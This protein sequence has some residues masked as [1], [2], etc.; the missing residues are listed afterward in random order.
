[1]V[2]IDRIAEDDSSQSRKSNFPELIFRRIRFLDKTLSDE[3]LRNSIKTGDQLVND[4]NTYI[5]KVIDEDVPEEI[6]ERL[7]ELAGLNKKKLEENSKLCSLLKAVEIRINAHQRVEIF[8]DGI[9]PS[10]IRKSLNPIKKYATLLH[11]TIKSID[12]KTSHL[13][14]QKGCLQNDVEEAI[15]RV[16]HSTDAVLQDIKGQPSS[17]SKPSTK[18]RDQH[19][20]SCIAQDFE[21]YAK[22]KKNITYGRYIESLAEFISLALE[23]GNINLPGYRE[24]TDMI[25]KQGCG[26]KFKK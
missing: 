1:M 2:K 13:L 20:I 3:E 22:P 26:E 15:E 10:D 14:Y 12:P 16:I 8:F 5:A 21:N 4:G 24:L 18:G 9:K 17:R 6:R 11:E 23:A 19:T 25:K 7:I